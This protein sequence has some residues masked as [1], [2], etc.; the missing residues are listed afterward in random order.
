M[1]HEVELKLTLPSYEVQAFLA[2]EDLGESQG[3]PL[4]L[5][6]QYFDTEDLKLNQSHAAL[7][8][9][10]SQHGYKQ[11]LKNKGKAIAGLHQRGEW[12][13]DIAEPVIDWSLFPSEL[14]IDPS[15]KNA[16]K[17]IFKTD[18]QRHVWIRKQGESEIE[19]VLDEG[20]IKNDDNNIALCE[21]EL[22]LKTGKV[23]DLF[24]FALQ[25]AERHPLVPCD[26]N[27]AERGYHLNHP[28]LSFFSA[29]DF[30]QPNYLDVRELLQESLTRISRRWDDF[31]SNE[32]WW[33]LLVLSRQLHGVSGLLQCLETPDTLKQRWLHLTEQVLNILG[34]ARTV[35]ALYVDDNSHSRGLK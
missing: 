29:Q 34:P 11:T 32:N 9:R 35:V 1:A 17:P 12:E 13:Y 18:F 5:D 8:I 16:I 28:D 14:N 31:S 27:K 15:L 7:R 33:A 6:N 3:E 19:L 10:K 21:I 4:M 26:I 25:L 20:V 2:D 22:E 30:S 23:E 24:D